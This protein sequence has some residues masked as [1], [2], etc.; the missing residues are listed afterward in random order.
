MRVRRSTAGRKSRSGRIVR[1]APIPEDGRSRTALDVRAPRM[2]REGRRASRDDRRN[3]QSCLCEVV[4]RALDRGEGLVAQPGARRQIGLV[5]VAVIGVQPCGAQTW[6]CRDQPIALGRLRTGRDA[7]A[8]HAHVEIEEQAQRD[9]R[10]DGGPRQLSNR[11]GVVCQCGE[12]RARKVFDELHEPFDVGAYRLVRHQHVRRLA[13][14]D[15]LR[16]GD[17]GALEL[18]DPLVQVHPDHFGELV[19][20]HVRPEALNAARHVDHPSDVLLDPIGVDQQRRGG[21]LVD[22]FDRV[23]GVGHDISPESESQGDRRAQETSCLPAPGINPQ[24][25]PVRSPGTH[26][27]RSSR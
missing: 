2:N 12:G 8:V 9:A 26:T 23:P 4:P 25:R 6:Q 20:L 15:H 7:G 21:N 5:K 16:F 24:A 18:G 27:Q 1:V 17:R 22:V 11:V 14:R 10:A 3:G 13:R 19:G